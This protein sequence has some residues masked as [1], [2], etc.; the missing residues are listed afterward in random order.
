MFR[1]ALSLIPAFALAACDDAVPETEPQTIDVQY[2][3]TDRG[4]L[5]Y[6]AEAVLLACDALLAQSDQISSEDLFEGFYSRGL[7]KRELLDLNGSEADLRNALE[8]E[9]ERDDVVRMLAWTLR[10][11]GDLEGAL[12]LYDRAIDM[13]PDDWQGYLS[14][15]VV[16]GAGLGRYEEA[17]SDCQ[18]AISLDFI[19]D[20]TVFFTSNALNKTGS[21]Q[22]AVELIEAHSDKEFTSARVYEE[23]VVA[24]IRLSEH[25]KASRALNAAMD[26]HPESDRFRQLASELK[27]Q[28]TID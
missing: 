27:E 21:H 28:T 18:K 2:C 22:D 19:T 23:Y 7:T 26:E 8:L 24:L 25:E 17:V 10:E 14:R 6:D 20:D 9:P 4:A 1:L 13:M 12:I 11:K 15:C 3:F 16:L 5:D